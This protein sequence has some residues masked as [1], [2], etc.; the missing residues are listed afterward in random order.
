[1][2]E[3]NQNY[4]EL[5]KK[6]NYAF[7]DGALLKR[8]LTHSSYANEINQR[9]GKKQKPT[10]AVVHNELLEFLGDAVLGFVITEE[11]FREQPEGDE[12]RLTLKRSAIICERSLTRCAREIGV[13]DYLFLGCTMDDG[14]SRELSSILSDAMEALFAAVYID[15]GIGAARRV[16]KEC[17]GEAIRE[18]MSRD[19]MIDHKTRLQEYYQSNDAGAH[20][21]YAVIEE[22]GPPHK[23]SFTSNV[24]VNG[25]VI[26]TGAGGTKKESEQMA[27]EKALKYIKG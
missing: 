13:G 11:L 25:R 27:A 7:K 16:I 1:M 12:G 6:I 23:R 21:A 22:S 10:G 14:Q 8:A 9:V 24:T 4:R 20:V 17:L 2:S 18:D 3:Q 5:E 19:S 26:G 15:G